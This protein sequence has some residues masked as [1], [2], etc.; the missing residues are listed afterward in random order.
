MSCWD[1]PE[2]TSESTNP[3]WSILVETVHTLPMYPHHTA[4]VRDRLIK[5]EPG[6]SA[7]D[8]FFRLDTSL[9]AEMVIL[10]ELGCED[11]KGKNVENG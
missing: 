3:L 1:S 9:G 7:K 6:I 8:L 11:L 2:E 5:E 10:H 4:Y